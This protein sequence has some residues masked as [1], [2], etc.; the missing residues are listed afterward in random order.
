[1]TAYFLEVIQTVP[2]PIWNINCFLT[3]KSFK[4]VATVETSI[5]LFNCIG[6]CLFFKQTDVYVICVRCSSSVQAVLSCFQNC[7]NNYTISTCSS[8][9][10]S[11]ATLPTPLLCEFK[12]VLPYMLWTKS[13]WLLQTVNWFSWL[14]LNLQKSAWTVLLYRN[15]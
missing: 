9:C 11:D 2:N 4:E 12:S 14:F 8:I 3:A 6:I 10:L 7:W 15:E 5:L 1:M 13:A